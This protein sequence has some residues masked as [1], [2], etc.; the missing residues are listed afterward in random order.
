MQNTTQKNSYAFKKLQAN[1][2]KLQAEQ[3]RG[4]ALLF[5]VLLTSVLLM[6]AIGISNIAYKELIFSAEARDSDLAFFSADTGVEC[7][8]YLDK[9]GI[10]SGTGPSTSPECSGYPLG[11]IGGGP[12]YQFIIPFTDGRH[13]VQVN[14]NK[15]FVPDPTAPT[16]MYTQISA[17]GYNVGATTPDACI[18]GPVG[19]QV[20]TRALSVTYPNDGTTGGTGGTTGTG[21]GGT[22]G[23]P[24]VRTEPADTSGVGAIVGGTVTDTGGAT[25]TDAGIDY[26][27]TAGSYPETILPTVGSAPTGSFN[28]PIPWDP[29]IPNH[30]KAWVKISPSGAKI[31]ADNEKVFPTP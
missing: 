16:D 4:I 5:V 28:F 13:C 1:S 30:Y 19:L 18:S 8:L 31:Y 26:G 11:I 17:V 6:V 27:P 10:F 12:T 15:A 14:I 7:A 29:T 3:E 21:G 20:V 24:I 22:T 25:I 2:Y 9:T 23:T